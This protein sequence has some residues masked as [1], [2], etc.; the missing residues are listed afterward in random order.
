LVD[1]NVFTNL[2]A[3]RNLR[4]AAD[5]AERYPGRAAD[6][7]VDAAEI[8]SWRKAADAIVVPFDEELG[9]TQQSAGFTRYRRWNFETTSA[10]AYPLLLNYPYY[11]LYSSQVIKQ[12]DL[13]HAL[14]LCGDQ[15]TPEQKLRDFNFYEAITVRDS[16]LSASVQAIVAAEV[17]H[18]QLAYDYFRET[19]FV[20]LLDLAG[21]TSD[22][23]HI[24]AL[25][26]TL[27]VVA[28]G[29]GGMRDHGATLT[30]APRLPAPLSRTNSS[31]A[32]HWRSITTTNR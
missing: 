26:G 17:G 24:A 25:S 30:F 7:G 28:A 18:T 6:L 15:F 10:D 5:V 12:A 4:T 9:V 14:Y 27:L 13:V 29:F 20:D 1:N 31:A 8:Q 11:L 22:G 2:M 16:T 21:N 19:A 3:A 23:L 32:G